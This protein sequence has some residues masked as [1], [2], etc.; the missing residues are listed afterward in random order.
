MADPSEE[1]A[2]AST[3]RPLSGPVSKCSAL[4]EYVPLVSGRAVVL[5]RKV[6]VGS[7]PGVEVPVHFVGAVGVVGLPQKMAHLRSGSHDHGIVKGAGGQGSRPS[8]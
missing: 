4:Y 5:G 6:G 8:I 1:K 2:G 7:Q 3:G